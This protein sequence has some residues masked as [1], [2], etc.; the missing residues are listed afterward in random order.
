MEP[1][2]GGGSAKAQPCDAAHAFF[3]QMTDVA[4]D[5]FAGNSDDIFKRKILTEGLPWFSR[6]SL[7]MC[8]GIYLGSR[9]QAWPFFLASLTRTR[10]RLT[11]MNS[12]WVA[13]RD[14]RRLYTST[15]VAR[16]TFLVFSSAA[17]Q[18]LVS[19]IPLV[20]LHGESSVYQILP[21]S[22]PFSVGPFLKL[23][24][25]PGLLAFASTMSRSIARFVE[26]TN[27]II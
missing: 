1:I 23:G 18:V 12:P 21:R 20:L 14:V 4:E 11:R 2:I 5:Y 27:L 3:R 24:P 8:L 9:G 19:S 6:T 7:G 10:T 22:S 13:P 25:M 26:V 16:M 15:F 17:S